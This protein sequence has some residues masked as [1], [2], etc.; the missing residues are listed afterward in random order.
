MIYE[1]EECA[2]EFKCVNNE[3]N[4][5]ANKFI[6]YAKVQNSRLDH[7]LESIG[8]G[9]RSRNNSNL[10]RMQLLLETCSQVTAR[11]LERNNNLKGEVGALM[12]ENEML[13][14]RIREDAL[15]EEISKG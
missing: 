3:G 6:T 5:F 12:H 15:G 10:I 2:K 13:L 1:V 7:E 14:E 11:I 4:L 8:K 9:S